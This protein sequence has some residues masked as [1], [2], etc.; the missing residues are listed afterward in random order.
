MTL[1]QL[2]G[3]L[4]TVGRHET[5]HQHGFSIAD[6]RDNLVGIVLELT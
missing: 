5:C 6:P 3:L 4:Q 2:L 1:A